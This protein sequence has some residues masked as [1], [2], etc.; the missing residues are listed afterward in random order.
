VHDASDNALAARRV[1]TLSAAA[2]SAARAAD[3]RDLAMILE[4]PEPLVRREAAIGAALLVDSSAAATLAARALEDDATTVRLEAL[5]SLVA[6][7]PGDSACASVLAALHDPDRHVVL[8]ALD[9]MATVCDAA[10]AVAPLDSIAASIADQ[11][12]TWHAPAHALLSLA[13]LDAAAAKQRIP[14]LATHA[15]PFARGWAARAAAA[16]G[17]TATLRTLATDEH[18][19]V[20][21]S[22][23]TGLVELAA[24]GPA[25]LMP[26]LSHDDGQLLITVADALAG[27]RDTGVPTALLDA[28]DRVSAQR[29]ETSRDPRTALLRRIGELGGPADADRVRPYLRDFDPAV[30]ALAADV[31]A[32][33]TGERVEPAPEPPA[34]APTP[35]PAA[36]DS[37][38]RAAIVLV[39][40]DG[41]EIELRLRPWLAPTNAARFARLA[42]SGYYDGLTFHRVVPNFVVQGGSPGANEFAGDGPFSRDELGIEGNWRGTVG[43]STR[44]R[45][46]G[47]A[48]LYVNLVD[49]I[50]LDHDYTIFGD[51]VRGMDVVDSLLEGAVIREVRVR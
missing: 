29:R 30:A 32:S 9:L 28:L 33:W 14:P 37:L 34:P 4:D 51:V 8:L 49:N 39:M 17:D 46:T 26:Q 47:D 7:S 1:R 23:I 50:R 11:P 6:V 40:E 44:G 20:R 41:R 19:N 13:S 24:A 42:A 15:S 48:Q 22:A 35:T 3:A 12:D 2:L 21:T 27:A 45:D 5:R 36:L 10:A 38:A 43:L 25:L 16:A 18:P 31:L